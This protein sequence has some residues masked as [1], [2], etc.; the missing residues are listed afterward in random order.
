MSATVAPLNVTVLG[1]AG[2]GRAGV[3]SAVNNAVA[4]VAGLL[5]V[6]IIPVA[7]G[8]TGDDYLVPESFDDGY[9]IGIVICAGLCFA[10]G[11]LALLVIRSPEPDAPEFET[12]HNCPLNGPPPQVPAEPAV[13]AAGG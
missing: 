10:G 1:S 11:A 13:A 8:I 2:A 9:R 6:A 12:P 7:A 4:R 3:A 5:A